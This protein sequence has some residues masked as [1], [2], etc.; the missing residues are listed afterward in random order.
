MVANYLR[1][2][3]FALGLLIGIQVPG[4]VDQYAKRVS[5]HRIEIA[6]NFAGFQDTANRYFGGNVE[7]LIAHHLASDDRAF[8]DEGTVIQGLHE[9]LVILTAEL[10][11]MTGPLIKQIVHVAFRPDKEILDETWSEY[12]YSVPLNPPAIIT[13]IAIGGLLA[14]LV[15]SLFA[16]IVRVGRARRHHA[17]ATARTR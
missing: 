1:L 4:F 13:G 8:R 12:T 16:G 5:A 11:A 7:A 10:A 3:V 2:I 14:I 9:R 6:R 15:E 17:G